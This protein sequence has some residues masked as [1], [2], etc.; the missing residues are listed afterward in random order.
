MIKNFVQR[1]IWTNALSEMG[2]RKANFKELS[3]EHEA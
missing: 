1:D 2:E 3:F